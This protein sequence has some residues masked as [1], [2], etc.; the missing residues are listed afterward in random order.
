MK[1]E[2]LHHLLLQQQDSTS[3]PPGSVCVE[4]LADC[5]QESGFQS[6]SICSEGGSSSTSGRSHF[7][8]LVTFELLRR[9]EDGGN[10]EQGGVRVCK[11]QEEVAEEEVGKEEV[12]VKLREL[13]LLL[14]LQMSAV[15][16][17]PR[18]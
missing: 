2:A 18:L 10:K 6:K 1:Q 15:H 7:L 14:N 13:L 3:A 17:R 8:P 11:R 9:S 5:T 4:M 12:G 16:Q